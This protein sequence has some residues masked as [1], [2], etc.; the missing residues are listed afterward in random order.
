MNWLLLYLA[1]AIAATVLSAAFTPVCRK[2]AWHT[3]FLDKPLGEMHK[4]HDS[5]KALMGGVAMAAAWSAVI[6][7]GVGLALVMPNSLPHAV[8]AHVPGVRSSLPLLVA[9]AGGGLALAV[10]GLRDDR[11]P[12]GPLKKLLW[13][14]VICGLVAT[15][16]HLR[17]TLFWDQPL[18]TWGMTTFWFLFIVN[19]F[20]FFD[21]MDGLASGM[22]I[23]GAGL[24]AVVAGF[25]GQHF[26]TA[27]GAATAGS[28]LGFYFYN[29]SPASIFM[30]DCGSHFL[31]FMLACLGSLTVF[32]RSETPTTAPV[33]IPLFILALPIFD[34]FAVC[35]IRIRAGKK[36]YHGDH[37]HISHR[38][39]KS[40]VSR[41]TAVLL[42][43]L[44][45]LA[46]GLGALPLM[47]LE[48]R[49]V[50]LV[51]LQTAA[52]LLIVTILQFAQTEDS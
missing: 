21:N 20:N 10:L 46:I 24:F 49:G 2:L 42:V 39:H 13:Q 14:L 44:L 41:K 3:N 15:N 8:Q 7:G 25:Q 29:K 16:E 32:Y 52:M 19:A 47:W 37:N 1:V 34:T 43:H 12:M 48:I 30:G 26:V 40:G 23:I 11:T 50:I 35:V 17:V 51:F 4:K 45:A 22:A 6:F 18:V 28:A 33:L 38:F 9:I 36:I 31:G 5:A 27:L